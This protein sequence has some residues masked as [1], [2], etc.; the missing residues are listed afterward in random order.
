MTLSLFESTFVT[1][2]SWKEHWIETSSVESGSQADSKVVKRKDSA[3]ATRYFL[4]I[5][6]RQTDSERRK[7]MHREVGVYETLSHS[8]IPR[9][10]ESNSHRFAESSYSLYL[11][12]EY[13]EGKNLSN[14]LKEL[15]PLLVDDALA[16][17]LALLDIVTYCHNEDCV[18]RDIKPDNIM[19]VNGN[20]G[21]PVLVDFGL[22]F[23]ASQA[24]DLGTEEGQ[25]LGNRFLRLPELGIDSPNKR[26]SR[27]DL[28]AVCGVL[29]YL[30][31]GIMPVWL[32]DE[33][34]QLPHQRTHILAH[35]SKLPINVA[36]L[37]HIFDRGFQLNI[38]SRWQRG[39]QLFAALSELRASTVKTNAGKS[40]D[41]LLSEL[42]QSAA[43]A[44]MQLAIAHRRTIECGLKSAQDEFSAVVH[45]LANI[46]A[47]SQGG[48]AIDPTALSG[49]NTLGATRLDGRG[50]IQFQFR[51]KIVGA[52]L[53]TTASFG[54]TTTELLRTDATLPKFDEIY[55]ESLR[56][57]V[58]MKLHELLAVG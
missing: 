53:V 41:D 38:N 14:L 51:V 44:S 32:V 10:I 42:T 17:T 56:L 28:T 13:I 58:V 6:R 11:V 31:T 47:M 19:L 37:L 30:L 5:L 24:A 46:V 27:S 9:L 57:L 40:S 16:L 2:Q 49:Q 7:R 50:E 43:G 26:D 18:H 1:A 20:V 48:Y 12:T 29:L 52:Q 54:N 33:Q 23:N 4:K 45:P 21:S 39:E 15:G 22:S 36:S 3:D 8:G 55:R 35:L 34:S 25:E